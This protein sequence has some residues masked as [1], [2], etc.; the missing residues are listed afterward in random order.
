MDPRIQVA[1]GMHLE[2]LQQGPHT[3][4]RGDERRHDHHGASG[5]GY[6]AAQVKPWQSQRAGEP[7]DGAVDERHREF[8]GGDQRDHTGPDAHPVRPLRHSGRR[9]RRRDPESGEQG[10][11]AEVDWRGMLEHQLR[12][13]LPEGRVVS[14]VV[15]EFTTTASDQVVADVRRPRIGAQPLR[16]LARAL[17]G[18]QGDPHLGFAGGVG[19]RLH[20]VPVAV[21]AR[22]LHAAVD[23][24]RVALEDA[25]DQTHVLDVLVPVDRGAQPQAGDGVAHREV[26]HRLPLMLGAHRRFHRRAGGIEP[27]LQLLAQPRGARAMFAHALQQLIHER[28]VGD[29]RKHR[30]AVLQLGGLVCG[31]EAIRLEAPRATFDQFLGQPTQML[32]QRELEHARPRPQLADGEWCDRLV[33]VDESLQSLGVESRVAVAE[34]FHGHGVHAR[35]AGELARGQLGKLSVVAGRKVPANLAHLGFDQVKIV[36]Q[37]LGCGRDRLATPY[38]AGEEAIR[39]TEH[40]RVVGQAA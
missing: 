36:E 30:Q 20:R 37:P 22:E 32:D 12:Q 7:V 1:E 29:V 26:I 13:S 34:K 31:E 25:L 14:H 33:G 23:A 19:Q 17:D 4:V 28:D 2:V 16:R 9:H 39:L 15:F 8:A 35:R 21:A 3:L 24:G 11:R 18:A 10:A 6:A 38:V 40:A 5:F 27:L